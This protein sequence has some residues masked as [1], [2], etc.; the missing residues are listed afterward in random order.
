[1]KKILPILFCF[2][3]FTYSQ[4]KPGYYTVNATASN[5]VYF[6]TTPDTSTKR[7]AYFNKPDWVF[8]QKIKNDFG[9]TCFIN[10]NE[11]TSVGWLLMQYLTK[12]TAVVRAKVGENIFGNFKQRNNAINAYSVQ[13]KI[14]KG[15]RDDPNGTPN[16]YTV[17]FSDSAIQPIIIGCCEAYLVNEGDLDNDGMD[18]LSVFQS[19]E[20][21]CTYNMITYSYKNGNWKTIVPLFLIPT[22]CETFD[23][24]YIQ[25]QVFKLADGIYYYDYANDGLK[26]IKTKVR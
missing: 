8:I 6:Y 15:D 9:Y 21:G 13:T 20:N 2:P 10:S 22:A 3:L 14:Q 4:A 24:A 11:K 26:P 1:M 7:K 23:A 12:D 17:F 16:E 18:E 25:K 19:P 5:K